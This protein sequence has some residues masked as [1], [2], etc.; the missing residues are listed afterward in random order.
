MNANSNYKVNFCKMKAI[1]ANFNCDA[2]LNNGFL[3]PI[4]DNMET[5]GLFF[6][7]ILGGLY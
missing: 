2:K 4:F 7:A 3:E 1:I 5:R 6:L